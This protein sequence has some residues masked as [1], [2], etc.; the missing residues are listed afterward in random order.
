MLKFLRQIS[1]DISSYWFFYFINQS[2]IPCQIT[3]DKI[4][5]RAFMPKLMVKFENKPA[6]P[7]GSV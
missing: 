2:Y 1:L 5:R 3:N 7:L 4:K 6:A